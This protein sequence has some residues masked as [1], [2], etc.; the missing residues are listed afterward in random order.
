MKDSPIVFAGLMPHAPILVPG[1]GRERLAEARATA[2]A[3]TAVAEHA[4]A[5]RPHTVVL[6]SP[7]SPRRPGAFGLWQTPR[8]RGS[9]GSFGSAED[10][11]DLP[12]DQALVERLAREA[13]RRGLRTWAIAREPLDHGALVPLCYLA[14]AKWNGPTV[15]LS[16]NYPG[17]GGLEALGQAIVTAAQ[18]LERRIAIIASGDMSHRLTRSAPGGFHPEAHRFDETFIALLREGS[19]RQLPRIDAQLQEDA[20]EDVMD[21]TVVAAAAADY[22]TDGHRLLSYEGPF[23]VG[24]GV[25]IL[26]EAGARGSA[27]PHPEGSAAAVISRYEDLPAVARRAVE[28]EFAHTGEAIPF[29]AAGV[30][31]ERRAVFVTLRHA[32]GELRG[33]RGRLAPKENDLVRETWQCATAAAF[34]DYRFPPLIAAELPETRFSVTVLG[35]LESV[36]SPSELDPAVFGVSVA[37][38]DGRRGVL[39]P[40]IAGIDTVK[41]QLAIARQKAGIEP[42]EWVKL[43]RFRAKSYAETR[44][45]AAEVEHDG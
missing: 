1:V 32:K 5:A 40:A 4:V 2:T 11:V 16:L 23:G 22:R 31:T 3:M 35:E 26:F 24:Y 38:V 25:A 29:H 30:L 15:I 41:Q 9:L 43:Q 34:H 8:L 42:E 36:V 10:R 17:E 33:C 44:P 28:A 18:G 19:F 12:L 20:G 13:E 45:G 37:A 6:I 39:L 21:S 7:H 14:A 27:P